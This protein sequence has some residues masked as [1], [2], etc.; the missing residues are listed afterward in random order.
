LMADPQILIPGQRSIHSKEMLPPVDG[1][2]SSLTELDL[3]I[4]KPIHRDARKP[5]AEIVAEVGATSKTVRKRLSKMIR[6]NLITL[7]TWVHSVGPEVIDF[8]SFVKVWSSG[9]RTP[10]LN[11][12][13]NDPPF[14]LMNSWVISNTPN[15]LFFEVQTETV[16]QMNALIQN[17]HSMDEV[18]SISLF[19]N[20]EEHF[21]ESWLDR[22]LD[23][24]VLKKGVFIRRV[25]PARLS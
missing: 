12:M 10:V 3:R 17:L 25:I 18:E 15:T 1:D 2:L 23:E 5:L 4:V 19:I 16:G 7:S 8:G 6:G 9:C 11:M 21:I 13:R 20:L 14:F 24:M 22:M